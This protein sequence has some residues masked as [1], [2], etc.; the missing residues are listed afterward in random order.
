MTIW[1]TSDP[2]F[3]H[4]NVIDYCDRPFASVDHMDAALIKSYHARIG[5]DDT[6]WCL[7]DFSFHKGP[8]TKSILASLPGTWHLVQGNHDKGGTISAGFAS[9]Q[10]FKRLTAPHA[11]PD[12]TPPIVMSHFPFLT[13]WG[14]HRGSTCLHGHAHGNLPPS[15]GVRRL[16]VGVDAQYQRTRKYEPI[17]LEEVTA[18]LA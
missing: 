13:W 8:R 9:V 17:S 14:S 1:F 18:L 6:V 10:W 2:H 12:G 16:D 7:G 5:P 15:P 11:L 4:A 3:G